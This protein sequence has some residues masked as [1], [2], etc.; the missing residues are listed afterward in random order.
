MLYA[1]EQRS[2]RGDYKLWSWAKLLRGET[3]PR[4]AST[5]AGAEA[6]VADD[7]ESLLMSPE[8]AVAAYAD[9]LSE[10]ADSTFS[11]AIEDDEFRAL[12]RQQESAQKEADRWTASGGKYS[13]SARPDPDAGVRAMRMVDGGAIVMGAIDSS[14]LIELQE[15]AKIEKRSLTDT[16]RALHGDQPESSALR[17][18]FLDAVALH[19]PVAGSDERIRLVGVEHVAVDVESAGDLSACG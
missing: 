9:V 18:T 3:L 11:D 15:C 1:F 2:A 16:Q 4:F 12:L 19:V 10:E 6:V 5:D 8:N 13:F 17:T 7:G 14:Q